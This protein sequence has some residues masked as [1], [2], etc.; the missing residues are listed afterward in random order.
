[1]PSKKIRN[2]LDLIARDVGAV[3]GFRARVEEEKFNAQ[4]ARMVLD[5]RA[6]AGLTQQELADLAGTTQPVIARLEDADYE[7]HSLRMLR[8]IARA[9]NRH[10]EIRLVVD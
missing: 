4:V 9:L 6:A 3:P 5:A 1:M 8:R 2:A 10:L 7:G